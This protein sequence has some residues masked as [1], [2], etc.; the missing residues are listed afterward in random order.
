[1]MIVAKKLLDAL[2]YELTYTPTWPIATR[3]PMAQ[4]QCS[5]SENLLVFRGGVAM[6]TMA[7]DMLKPMTNAML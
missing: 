7:N 4:R 5:I 1:M 6:T 3:K 2:A